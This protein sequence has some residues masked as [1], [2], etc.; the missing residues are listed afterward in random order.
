MK[1]RIIACCRN[2]EDLLPFFLQYYSSFADKIIIHDCQS[3]DRSQEI[4]R[5]CSKAELIIHE[6]KDVDE[7][8]LSGIKNESWKSDRD[9]YDWNFAVDIDEFIYHSNMLE[10][11]QQYQNLG[12]T[13][14]H[15]SGYDIYALDFPAFNPESSIID[16]VQ[17]G[18]SN[19]ALLSKKC[20]FNSKLVN[21]NY[22]HGCHYSAP[23]GVVK[24]SDDN[25]LMLLHLQWF[26]YEKFIKKYQYYAT[27]MSQ[28]NIQKNLGM[29]IIGYANI[30]REE[31]A[32]VVSDVVAGNNDI[33]HLLK[34]N[35]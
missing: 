33:R 28:Y 17:Y 23:D 10:K 15:I 8:F 3:T 31:F 4:I 18:V 9:Q 30:G 13:V 29:H 12:V 34:K 2:E 1:I 20:V 11:L 32:H 7:T 5:S 14:P 26:G 21:I 22:A 19:V 35:R 27:I 6:Q 24:Y 16:H 25:E